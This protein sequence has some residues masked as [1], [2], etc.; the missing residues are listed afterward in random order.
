V[1]L[2]GEA[3]DIPDNAVPCVDPPP[4]EGLAAP[5]PAREIRVGPDG[6]WNRLYLS[7]ATHGDYIFNEQSYI[8]MSMNKHGDW[9]MRGHCGA[10]GA[11][12]NRTTKASKSGQGRPLACLCDFLLSCP[13]PVKKDH[14][15]L[16]RPCS[17][18]TFQGLVDSIPS[19]RFL[20][21]KRALG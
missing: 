5:P 16:S 14:T 12:R 21:E 17:S 7:L 11:E 15:A 2:E 18:T 3:P 13:G 19:G 9:D 10:C 4:P 6:G 20:L 8:R 1:F